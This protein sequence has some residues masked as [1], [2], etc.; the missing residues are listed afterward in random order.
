MNLS[1][2]LQRDLLSSS[3]SNTTNWAILLKVQ[4]ILKINNNN[5]HLNKS[6]LSPALQ[7]DP[8]S[9]L[10]G[11]LMLQFCHSFLCLTSL[12]GL[13]SWPIWFQ[14][15]SPPFRLSSFHPPPPP[16]PPN[17]SLFDLFT[18]I[19]TLAELPTNIPQSFAYT[20]THTKL[21]LSPF[22]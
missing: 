3:N 21:S 14:S 7:N 4:F 20:C 6:V 2:I 12:T 1:C 8:C 9:N 5:I 11:N 18:S 16:P 15:A 17:N 10:Y 22:Q 19:S 13:N